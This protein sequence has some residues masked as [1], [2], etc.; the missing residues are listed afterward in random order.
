MIQNDSPHIHTN[1]FLSVTRP[2][3]KYSKYGGFNLCKIE[4]NE[5]V[6]PSIKYEIFDFFLF[7]FLL[8]INIYL[9]QKNLQSINGVN[10]LHLF[11]IDRGIKISVSVALTVQIY[12]LIWNFKN[13]NKI[14]MIF[15]NF[16]VFDKEVCHSFDTR[17]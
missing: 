13:S 2:I 4:N 7:I 9:L 10:L 1:N 15:T 11:V 16:T 12:V 6:L 5:K 3:Y 8:S 14:L 17:H